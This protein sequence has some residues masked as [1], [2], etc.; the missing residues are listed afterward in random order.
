VPLVPEVAIRPYVDEDE[1]AVL[2][3]LAAS[4]GKTVDDRYRGFFRWKHLENPAGRSFMWVAEVDGVLAG[5]RSFLRWR[6]VDPGGAPVD[7][8]RAVDTATSPDFRGLGI[9]RDLTMHGLA[10]M[11]PY[12]VQFVFNTPNDQS[13]PG[14]LK[15]G[16]EVEGRVPVKVRPRSVRALWRMARARTAAE[17]WSLPVEVGRPVGEVELPRCDA[18]RP[19]GALTT[20]RTPEF[21]RWRYGGCPA[22]ASVAIPAADGAAVVRFRQRGNAVECTLGDVIGTT[23]RRAAGAAV[24]DAMGRAGGDYAIA[25]AVSPVG[26]MVSANRLGPIQTRREVAARP[27]RLPLALTLGDVELF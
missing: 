5:F 24:R 26:G 10:E 13:R 14:Y 22:V 4:L 18:P 8:V 7:A 21:L 11:R 6:F 25:A 3:L 17:P 20:D 9:F 12:G 2:D 23:D 19:A 27:N 16:W 1:P 15:M